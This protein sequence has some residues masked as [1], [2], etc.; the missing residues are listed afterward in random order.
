MSELSIIIA[1]HKRAEILQRC[2][3]HLQNQTIADQLEVIVV[4]DGHDDAT[5]A[6]C[7]DSGVRFFEIPK[8]QQG[9]A[10]NRGVREATAT[11]CMII[12]EDIFLDANACELH[13]QNATPTRVVLGYTTWDP[14]LEITPVMRWLEQSGW[15]FGYPHIEKYAQNTVPKHLQHR[16]TYTSHISLPTALAKK[17]PF[18]EDI[19]TYG[20][21]DVE[22][23]Q[24]LADAGAELYYEPGAKAFHHH[25]MT[26]EQSL[27]RM[28]TIGATTKKLSAALPNFD[29]IPRGWKRIAYHVIALLPTMAGKHRK[30]FLRGLQKVIQE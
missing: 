5:G 22:W 15:Q 23:G 9:V 10:R 17:H 18:R 3:E 14:E 27:Q 7:R 1:T 20:W 11:T 13:V 30:A 29:R 21:E 19:T 16:F 28:E 26:L 25:H 8:S 6:V 12:N 24:R 2:L 4:S